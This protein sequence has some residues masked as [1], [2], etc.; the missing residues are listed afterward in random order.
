MRYFY[1]GALFIALFNPTLSAI[2]A[3]GA[4]PPRVAAPPKDDNV[5]QTI[6]LTYVK[7]SEAIRTLRQDLF[8]LANPHPK[9]GV[10]AGI[11][12][13]IQDDPNKSITVCG[14][15]EA[16][17]ELAM[18]LHLL[19]VK[20][21]LIE[22]KTRLVEIDL[23]DTGV[24]KETLV[25]ASVFI[26]RNS[27]DFKVTVPPS[28]KSRIDL[29]ITPHLDGDKSVS[30]TALLEI[31]GDANGSDPRAVRSETFASILRLRKKGEWRTL[32]EV[33]LTGDPE[34]RYNPSLGTFITIN[35]PAIFPSTDGRLLR[36]STQ[37][38][39]HK[40]PP[41]QFYCCGGFSTVFYRLR[42]QFLYFLPDPQGQRSFGP[43]LGIEAVCCSEAA[44]AA[45]RSAF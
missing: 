31:R 6:Q 7:P 43:T 28:L 3:F 24:R 30:V 4:P 2:L 37:R 8:D 15:A 13:I 9:S 40:K 33:S 17:A 36:R 12:R 14:T 11:R 29:L 22:V 25:Q 44:I 19:D 26:L 41:H 1:F 20:P 45:A 18:L 34:F 32:K 39:R 42:W 21:L 23:T 16:V 5:T 38:H 10:P 35:P 27:S